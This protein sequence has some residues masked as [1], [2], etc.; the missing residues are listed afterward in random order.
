MG[1]SEVGGELGEPV[2]LTVV[3]AMVVGE[4]VG[5]RV[6]WFKMAVVG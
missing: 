2:G 3:G 1:E 6:G 5:L 4:A